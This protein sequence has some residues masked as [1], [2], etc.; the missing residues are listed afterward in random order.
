MEPLPVVHLV[1]EPTELVVG[2]GI[3]PALAQFGLLLADVRIRRSAYQFSP[4]F[5]TA[6][7]SSAATAGQ[8]RPWPH[9]AYERDGM[10]QMRAD[11]EAALKAS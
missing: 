4:G 1:Q 2:I 5:P 6:A 9:V 10:N 8:N 7:M 3:V 11:I